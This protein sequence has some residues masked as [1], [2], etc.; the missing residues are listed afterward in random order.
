MGHHL[1]APFKQ[2]RAS[3]GKTRNPSYLPGRAFAAALVDLLVPDHGGTATVD[4]V[5]GSVL[6]LPGTDALR[7]PL[8]SLLSVAGDDLGSFMTALERW[9]DDQMDRVS[10]A[11]KRWAKRWLIIVGLSVAVLFQVDTV[12]VARS[13]YSD[14]PLRAAVV[15]AAGNHTLCPR[16]QP[17]EQ[18]RECVR[19]ELDRLALDEGLPVGWAADLPAGAGGWLVKLLGWLLTALAASLGA[20]FWF[21]ALTR[22]GSLRNTGTR[23]ARS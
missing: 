12:A 16:D 14:A 17:L 7:G 22:L 11:Y 5:R 19:T 15:S 20:P 9:Y 21:D 8:L 10:G 6:A 1:I 3:G 18:A 4:G 13:L 2:S 23:P